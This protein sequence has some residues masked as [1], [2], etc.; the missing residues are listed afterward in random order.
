MTKR[1]YRFP[2]PDWFGTLI[3]RFCQIVIIFTMVLFFW[4]PGQPI[5]WVTGIA[6][7]IGFL[8]GLGLGEIFNINRKKGCKNK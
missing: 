5:D 3:G 6:L 2:G 8:V 7:A 1:G 4:V